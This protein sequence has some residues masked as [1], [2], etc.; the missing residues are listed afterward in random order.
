VHA[1]LTAVP[2]CFDAAPSLKEAAARIRVSGEVP[3]VVAVEQPGAHI[4]VVQDPDAHPAL[5]RLARM[6]DG[7][8]HA[9]RLINSLLSEANIAP[10]TKLASL[11]HPCARTRA[12]ADGPLVLFPVFGPVALTGKDLAWV[13]SHARFESQ[14]TDHR[15]LADAVANAAVQV[16]E[17]ARPRAVVLILGHETRDESQ[18]GVREVEAYLRSIRVPLHVWRTESPR[19]DHVWESGEYISTG[20]KLR[21]AAAEVQS[22]LARQWI[23]WL[24]GQLTPDQIQIQAIAGSQS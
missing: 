3:R 8:E 20:K 19:D 7:R 4:A 23:V 1:G 24:E 6:L 5:R 12:T 17:N 10:G 18:Y 9:T 2:V 14:P 15:K 13:V 21:N 11:I 16:A 22:E